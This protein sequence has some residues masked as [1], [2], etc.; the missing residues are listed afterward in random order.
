MAYRVDFDVRMLWVEVEDINKEEAGNEQSTGDRSKLGQSVHTVA[1]A[2]SGKR[3]YQ[4]TRTAEGPKSKA[5]GTVGSV[6]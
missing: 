1:S 5:V 2:E 6:A 4:H 3:S